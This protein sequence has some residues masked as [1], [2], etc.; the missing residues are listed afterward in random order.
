MIIWN[1]I[2][3]NKHRGAAA[4]DNQRKS[5][6]IMASVRAVPVLF[7]LT[8]FRYPGMICGGYENQLG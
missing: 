4:A 8:Q 2:K 3:T 7:R 6:K 1:G 5:A